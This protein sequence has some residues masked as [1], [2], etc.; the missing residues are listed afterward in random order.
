[1][2]TFIFTDISEFK[3]HV[4]GGVNQSMSMASLKPWIE[5]AMQ[6][7]V[8]PWLGAGTWSALVANMDA[9]NP[10]ADLTAL[11]PYVQRP[12]ALLTMYE[13]SQIGNIQVGE[14]GLYRAETDDLKSPFKYQETAYRQQMLQHGFESIERMLN[15][16]EDNEA[17]YPLWQADPAYQRNK[18]HFI[19]TALDFRLLY[20]KLLSRYEFEII[21]P[22][23]EEVETFAILPIIGQ[24]QY[25]DLKEGIAL[26]ALTADEQALIQLIRRA[27]SHF[28]MQEAIERHW[29]Q[30][31]GNRVVQVE[32]LEP[33]GYERE[34]SAQRAPFSTKWRHHQL[35]ANRHI[36]YIRHYLSS[37]LETFPLYADHLEEE[38]ATEN[39]DTSQAADDNLYYSDRYYGAFPIPGVSDKKPIPSSIKRL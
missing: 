9:Q 17:K 37:R 23:M 21:R 28:T 29:V 14:G 12:V 24:A 1:M 8:L 30:F 36:S 13:Y 3:D 4:G 10:D 25:D 32:T 31:N 39:T 11:L 18:E 19:N 20:G 5:M 22:I 2:A 38:A 34:G 16:L 27:V 6:A 26:K 15:Y 35:L 33:Q 7:H